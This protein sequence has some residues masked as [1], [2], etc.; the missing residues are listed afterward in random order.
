MKMRKNTDLR[1][2]KQFLKK[3]T[4]KKIQAKQMEK[5]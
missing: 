5:K 1:I 4:H 3:R 2:K